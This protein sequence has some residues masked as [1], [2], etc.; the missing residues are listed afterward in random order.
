[1]TSTRPRQPRGG[2]SRGF[3]LQ[4]TSTFMALPPK[5]VGGELD[6]AVVALEVVCGGW[7][8]AAFSQR[9]RKRVT[10]S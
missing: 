9:W 6:P 7:P 1:M 10:S 8:D 4:A 5:R 3:T 2:R